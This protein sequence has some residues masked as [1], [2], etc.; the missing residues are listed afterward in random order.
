VTGGTVGVAVPVVVAARVD[1]A[2]GGGVAV[3]VAVGA[4]VAVLVGEGAGVGVQVGA[5]AWPQTWFADAAGDAASASSQIRRSARGASH[6]IQ[7]A[8]IPALGL[9]RRL[10]AII[11]QHYVFRPCR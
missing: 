9:T 11:P 2:A 8:S 7:D 4:S 5:C 6:R 10:R 3:R 1:V